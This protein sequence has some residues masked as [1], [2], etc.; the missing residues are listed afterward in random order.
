MRGSGRREAIS[1]AG[2]SARPKALPIFIYGGVNRMDYLA[3]AK[4]FLARARDSDSPPE[5]EAHL[6][7]ATSLLEK[8][9]AAS[10]NVGEDFERD[11]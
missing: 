10:E 3:E 9:V 1:T 7:A 8:V 5:K 11:K 6:N 4:K 2:N